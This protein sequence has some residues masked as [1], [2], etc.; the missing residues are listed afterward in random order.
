MKERLNDETHLILKNCMVEVEALLR[1]EEALLDRFAEELLKR[2][3]LEFDDIEAIFAEFGKKSG[4]IPQ[5]TPG[6]TPPTP[7]SASPGA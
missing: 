6:E 4:V 5:N 1:K 7:P 2:E 3:E